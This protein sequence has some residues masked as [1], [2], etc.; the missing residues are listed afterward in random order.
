MTSQEDGQQNVSG[1]T[2]PLQISAD[3]RKRLV[4]A[5]ATLRSKTSSSVGLA[6]SGDTPSFS[7]RGATE[8]LVRETP[9]EP[10]STQSASTSPSLKLS[11]LLQPF[12]VE[13][14]VLDDGS[15]DYPT[16]LAGMPSYSASIS[17]GHSIMDP[18][19]GGILTRQIS[20]ALFDHFM[21]EMNAKW[22]YILDPH[23]DSHDEVRRRSH[24]LFAAVLFCSS[25]FVSY[26][27]GSL[28]TSTDLF[29]QSRLC[30]LARS[31][32]VRKLAEGDKSIETVQ[33]IYLLVCWKEPDDEISY[34]HCGYAFRIVQDWDREQNDPDKRLSA[35]RMR[36]WLSLFRQDIQQSLS[37]KRRA[38]LGLGDEDGAPS[39]VDMN[40]W[41]K[42]PY[43]LPL[44]VV[45]CC[46]GDLQRLH[47]RLRA[48][49]KK[50][51]S[52]MLSCLLEL[53]DSELNKW[54]STWQNHLEEEER[55]VSVDDSLLDQRLFN[56]G[57]C[58]LNTIFG[59]WEQSVKLNVASAILRQA[60][61]TSAGPSSSFGDRTPLSPLN[62]DLSAATA[63]L[64]TDAP[65]LSS[66]VEAAFVMLRHLLSIS[67]CDLRR[68]P[69]SIH[70]L[71]PNAALFLCLLLCLPCDGLLGPSFQ[72]TAIGLVQDTA[73]HMAQSVQSPQDTI[74]LNAAYLDSLA[75]LLMPTVAQ[76]APDTHSWNTP[77]TTD[78]NYS[79]RASTAE[80][81]TMDPAEAAFRATS[82]LTDVKSEFDGAES[83]RE[84][85]LSLLGEPKESLHAERDDNQLDPGFYW[86][87]LLPMLEAD[88]LSYPA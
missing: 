15:S 12:K 25:K 48:M 50:A 13:P 47:I 32:V 16:A 66:G 9:Q 5:L 57:S 61:M 82:V 18:I 11:W 78:H 30:S 6:T 53:M 27:N 68:S 75:N 26:S 22:E 36:T 49:V 37:F 51:S 38:S 87:I 88:V 52:P 10:F 34:L 21:L 65:G 31:L 28:T 1:Q 74:A 72:S 80:L 3:I 63:L 55:T 19:E 81:A 8:D 35:R 62:F 39:V 7:T 24:L 23:F 64:S 29:L 45:A 59:L 33:A 69:D 71:G 41:L 40:T 86:E 76:P 17:L 2:T 46:C 83:V 70:L 43:S 4:A 73:R 56:P 77:P 54:R 14:Q 84:D 60:L 20:L 58:H 79:N 67:S 85:T 44:D 42:M